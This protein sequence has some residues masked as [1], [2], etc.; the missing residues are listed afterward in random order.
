[1]LKVRNKLVEFEFRSFFGFFLIIDIS[2]VN[3]GQLMFFGQE[4]VRQNLR[5]SFEYFKQALDS[6]EGDD[7][8]LEYSVA[9][10]KYKGTGT[11][12]D[13]DGAREM[14]E[15]S[16]NERHGPLKRLK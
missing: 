16:I 6:T 3:L 13:P 4:G 12:K 7:S 9:I 8:N 1:M 2:V 10:M 15:K 14:Y 11:L 5:R